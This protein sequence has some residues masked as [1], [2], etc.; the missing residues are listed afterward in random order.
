VPERA[1]QPCQ[2][3]PP[4]AGRSRLGGEGP[5]LQSASEARPGGP[6]APD[7]E[8]RRPLTPTVRV[9]GARPGAGHW[10]PCLRLHGGSCRRR[11]PGN[12]PP[13]VILPGSGGSCRPA[14]DAERGPAHVP[15]H[16][17]TG[18]SCVGRARAADHRRIL[19]LRLRVPRTKSPQPILLHT[20]LLQLE[21]PSVPY[22]PPRLRFPNGSHHPPVTQLISKSLSAPIP[23]LTQQTL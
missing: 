10:Q 8:P 9:H 23:V 1:L 6:P 3:Q 22:L 13:G 2:T 7:S 5:H 14:T 19:P 20:T 11:L 12:N 16:D 15:S 17:A 21:S 4:A 18:P